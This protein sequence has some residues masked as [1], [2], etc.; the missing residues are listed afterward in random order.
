MEFWGMWIN[1]FVEILSLPTLLNLFKSKMYFCTF[2][3]VAVSEMLDVSVIKQ[4]WVPSS[5][6]EATFELRNQNDMKTDFW[7]S[8]WLLQSFQCKYKN[9]DYL[10]HW[11]PKCV[12]LSYEY[13]NNLTNYVVFRKNSITSFNFFKSKFLN[14]FTNPSLKWFKPATETWDLMNL[15][16]PTSMISP[17]NQIPLILSEFR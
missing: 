13:A 14:S 17:L 9:L 8:Q 12:F 6:V 4:F 15:P 16:N 10:D 11:Q 1:T 2:V 3:C 7:D 5:T